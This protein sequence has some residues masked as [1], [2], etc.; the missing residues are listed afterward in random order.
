[1]TADTRR[2]FLDDILSHP[3][4]DAARLIYADWLEDQD[5]PTA[6]LWRAPLTDARL[7]AMTEAQQDLLP[8]VRDH[9]LGV[10]LATGPVSREKAWNAVCAAYR[11]ANLPEPTIQI[12][13]ASPFAGA[14]G[15]AMLSSFPNEQQVRQQVEQQVRQ[16]V[17]QQVWQQVRQQVG[18]QIWQQ[19]GQQIWQQVEQQVRQQVWQQVGQQIWQQVGQQI[20]QQIWQQ[21]GQQIW[22]QVG[23]QIYRAGY[24]QHD[25]NWL[26]FYAVMQLAGVKAAARLTPLMVLAHHCGWWWPFSGAVI[27]TERPEV[28][29]MSG[30]KLVR[31]RYSDGFEVTPGSKR[32]AES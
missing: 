15:A 24:G 32:R 9:W 27:L 18:Q 30:G 4:D 16:Q 3:E 23:Q 25:A 11:A 14:I 2:A 12:W 13:L 7:D 21:V 1:M 19:V 26:A 5:D 8:L 6:G 17:R 20:W 31:I 10:G 29:E 22:Q 28:L